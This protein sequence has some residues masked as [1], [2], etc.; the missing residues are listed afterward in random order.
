MSE[1][2]SQM[3]LQWNTS[4]AS[5]LL[6]FPV[7]SRQ[8]F[9][10]LEV[11]PESSVVASIDGVDVVRIAGQTGDRYATALDTMLGSG[12]AHISFELAEDH[13]SFAWNRKQKASQQDHLGLGRPL[14][15]DLA[16]RGSAHPAARDL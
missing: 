13:D 4:L 7:F 14:L 11:T 2:C 1:A 5:C 8:A 9:R 16:R 15:R 3:S 10:S 6:P 12:A